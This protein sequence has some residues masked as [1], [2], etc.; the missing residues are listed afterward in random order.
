M[1]LGIKLH[2]ISNELKLMVQYLQASSKE[3]REDAYCM[4]KLL[5]L[6][7]APDGKVN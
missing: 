1:Y 4:L 7:L 6:G 3:S 2:K 5:K